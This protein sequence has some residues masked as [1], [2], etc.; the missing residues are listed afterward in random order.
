METK[1]ILDKEREL[2]A[3]YASTLGT[4]CPKKL[5]DLL[6][7]SIETEFITVK[8]LVKAFNNEIDFGGKVE[9]GKLKNLLSKNVYLE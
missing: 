6:R 2:L 8:D 1:Q 3:L 9:K 4:D 5:E 7:C